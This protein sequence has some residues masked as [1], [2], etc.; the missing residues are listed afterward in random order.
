MS[1]TRQG[2]EVD[3]HTNGYGN[4][5]GRRYDLDASSRDTSVDGRSRSRGPAAGGGYGGF[6]NT[7]GPQRIAGPAYLERRQA[8]RRS[9][10]KPWGNSRSRSRPGGRFG[11]GSQQVEGL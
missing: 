1:W 11:E 5:F 9:Q 2:N 6:G 10:D 7:V 3:G 4:G 8:N